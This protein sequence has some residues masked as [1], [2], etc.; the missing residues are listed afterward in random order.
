MRCQI[1]GDREWGNAGVYGRIVAERQVQ[2]LQRTLAIL[3]KVAPDTIL[4]VGGARGADS[5]AEVCWNELVGSGKQTECWPAE[6][7]KY[8][9]RAGPI[10]NQQMID[11]SIKR[12]TVDGHTLDTAIVCHPNLQASKGTKDMVGRLQ[13]L[14]PA[15]KIM[16]LV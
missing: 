8:G 15:E 2:K 16:Y 9:K 13:K 12:G 7:D 6:W 11:E 4:I 14:L 1:T 3:Y 5:I 10:R